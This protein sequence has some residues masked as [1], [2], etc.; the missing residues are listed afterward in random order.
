MG[1]SAFQ[2][3]SSVTLTLRMIVAKNIRLRRLLLGYT[4]E[5][6]AALC[7]MHD[8]YISKVELGKVSVGLDNLERLAKALRVSPQALLDPVKSDPSSPE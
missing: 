2:V 6:L 3:H 7:A 8:N 5:E 1:A 4:Q